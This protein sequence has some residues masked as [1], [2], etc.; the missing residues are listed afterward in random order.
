LPWTTCS[1]VS[2]IALAASSEHLLAG[3]GTSYAWVQLKDDFDVPYLAKMRL[4]RL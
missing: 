2:D 1:L 4:E 3:V